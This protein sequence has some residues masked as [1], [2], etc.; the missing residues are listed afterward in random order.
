[1]GC[2]TNSF[3]FWWKPERK[4]AWKIEIFVLWSIKILP[5]G[6]SH[7]CYLFLFPPQA[8]S[9]VERAALIGAVM[10]KKVPTD[11]HYSVREEELRK[12]V[13]EDKAAGLIPFY[14]NNNTK[15]IYSQQIGAN[16]H[17]DPL[18][19]SEQCRNGWRPQ[20]CNF[21]SD[22]AAPKASGER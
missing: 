5:I 14:V 8:H 13:E 7:K 17:I 10:M 22:A 16:K 18:P 1:M 15:H 11:E 2:Y 6:L 3:L 19:V 21:L 20:W 4:M 9:S 12:M